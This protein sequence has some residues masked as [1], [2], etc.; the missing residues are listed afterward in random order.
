VYSCTVF[1]GVLGFFI[2]SKKLADDFKEKIAM[3]VSSK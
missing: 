1:I 3:T 2:N